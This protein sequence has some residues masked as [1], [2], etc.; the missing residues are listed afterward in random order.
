[1]NSAAEII[2]ERYVTS[3]CPAIDYETD[4]QT[5]FNSNGTVTDSY[6]YQYAFGD[7]GKAFV[8]VG[9]GGLFSLWAGV[10]PSVPS[11]QPG[12]YLNPIGVQS[13]A[14]YVP[15]TASVV[16]GEW[17]V[18]NGTGL[19]SGNTVEQGGTVFPPQIG[20]VQ[21]L[22]NNTP[23]APLLRH[24]DGYPGFTAV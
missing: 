11:T 15:I 17:V 24:P 8:A 2:H 14:S 3:F 16:P 13:A 22:V 6:G 1:M 20:G 12:V 7:G 4:D 9:A 5:T 21:V 23:G 18:L 10:Q 19:A